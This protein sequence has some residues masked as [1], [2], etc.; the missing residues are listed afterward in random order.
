[1]PANRKA[2]PLAKSAGMATVVL[3]AA[4]LWM[5]Y[6]FLSYFDIP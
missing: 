6:N 5:G 1:M 2:M 3:I 4:I